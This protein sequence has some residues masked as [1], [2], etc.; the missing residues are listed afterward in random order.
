MKMLYLTA[1][2]SLAGLMIDYTE[3]GKKTIV[4]ADLEENEF[5]EN[6]DQNRIIFSS[7]NLILYLHI[8]IFWTEQYYS[9]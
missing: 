1:V 5:A 8:K 6:L 7:L 2:S 9:I 3:L 4:I